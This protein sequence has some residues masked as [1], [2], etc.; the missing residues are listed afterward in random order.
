MN[1]EEILCPWC[2]AYSPA[3][4]EMAEEMGLCAWEETEDE[5]CDE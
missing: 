4:C 3:Q 2:G 1:G 5:E